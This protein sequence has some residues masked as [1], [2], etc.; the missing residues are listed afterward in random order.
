MTEES[1]E[2]RQIAKWENDPR[3]RRLCFI[4]APFADG[5]DLFWTYRVSKIEYHWPYETEDT[6]FGHVYVR[7]ECLNS[8]QS[9]ASYSLNLNFCLDVQSANN[10]VK[11]VLETISEWLEQT[12]KRGTYLFLG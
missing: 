12:Q 5:K 10:S 3:S 9:D 2:D 6:K 4:N 7:L 11:N 8:H 1:W